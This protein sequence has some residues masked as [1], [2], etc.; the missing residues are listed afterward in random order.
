MIPNVLLDN[1]KRGYFWEKSG[2]SFDTLKSFLKKHGP[3]NMYVSYYGPANQYQLTLSYVNE[4]YISCNIED[5]V[6]FVIS[7]DR[8]T[9]IE[10]Q[11]LTTKCK[12]NVK[13]KVLLRLMDSF[14]DL[15]KINR[16]YL[17]DEAGIQKNQ[18]IKLDLT[19]LTVMKESKTFYEKYGYQ[20][21]DPE[22]DKYNVP[23]IDLEIHKKLLRF[24]DFKLF[25]QFLNTN[26]KEFV[27]KSLKKLNK[28]VDSFQYLHE[29]FTHV[30][31]FYDQRSS[32]KQL[33]LQNL[34]YNENYPWYSM[35]N[36]IQNQKLCM[37]KFFE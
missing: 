27:H 13:T 3:R 35:I 32:T 8:F 21:C 28:S 19:L 25:I 11:K 26:D 30:S 31:E 10:L 17:R 2:H 4:K 1:I 9:E 6:E 23:R 36:V 34:I 33:Q 12:I 15:F 18:N 37:E 20:H 14:A 16:I 24:F 7:K 22:T 5:C 29:F